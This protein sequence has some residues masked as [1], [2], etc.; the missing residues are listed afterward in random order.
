MDTLLTQR[1]AAVVLCLSERS[2]ERLRCSGL[3]PR[4][5]RVG[6]RSVRYRQSDLAAYV[7]ARA[8]RSTSEVVGRVR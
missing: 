7:E 5:V 2:I 3:G 8:V 6:Q 4:F 1:Q